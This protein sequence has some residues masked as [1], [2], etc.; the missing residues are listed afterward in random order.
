MN[1]ELIATEMGDYIKYETSI[2]EIDRIAKA[3]FKFPCQEFP[4]ESI[5][6]VRAQLVYDWI[7]SLRDYDCSVK[8]KEKIV[9]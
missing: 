9:N 1:F 7:L 3:V 5:T 6:S 8:E 2:N 4:N